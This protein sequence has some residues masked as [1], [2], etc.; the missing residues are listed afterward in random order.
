VIL[1]ARA[2]ST[3]AG[4]GSRVPQLPPVP[5]ERVRERGVERPFEAPCRPRLAARI[6]R[7]PL[8]KP[9]V[10]G[11]PAI[12]DRVRRFA[13]VSSCDRNRNDHR[14]N[15]V[16]MSTG[17]ELTLTRVAPSLAAAGGPF[18]GRL[19]SFSDSVGAS[20]FSPEPRLRWT[21]NEL[22]LHK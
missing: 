12:A 1:R 7:L 5:V 21:H 8:L 6:A 20:H 19:G 2:S 17:M 3:F 13:H 9:R 15:T 14:T 10:L 4:L 11:R 22:G 18:P 16:H